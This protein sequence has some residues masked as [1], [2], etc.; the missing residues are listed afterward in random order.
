MSIGCFLDSLGCFLNVFWMSFGFVGC[1]LGLLDVF[2]MS[3]RCVLDVF[4][5]PFGCFFDV[6]GYLLG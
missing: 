4:W 6:F 3:L 2:G 5:I 1:L